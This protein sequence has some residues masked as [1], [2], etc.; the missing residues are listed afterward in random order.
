MKKAEWRVPIFVLGVWL[1]RKK[2]RNRPS[3]KNS[4]SSSVGAG[5]NTGTNRA[6]W[7]E[8]H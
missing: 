5:M 3:K 4:M 1:G 7:T 2:G 8:R 6:E